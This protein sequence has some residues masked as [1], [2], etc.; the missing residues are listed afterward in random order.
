MGIGGV[1]RHFF[2]DGQSPFYHTVLSHFSIELVFLHIF[3]TFPVYFICD[4]WR[5]Y[6]YHSIVFFLIYI[7]IYILFL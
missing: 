1:H 6:R 5:L 2:T 4:P 7:L 3:F